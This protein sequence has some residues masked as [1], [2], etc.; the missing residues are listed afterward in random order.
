MKLRP[1]TSKSARI[2]RLFLLVFFLLALDSPGVV[3]STPRAS[4]N[5]DM[6]SLGV[7]QSKDPICVGDVVNVT[8]QWGPNINYD[9]GGG[10]APVLPLAGPTRIKLQAG[11]GSFYPDASFTPGSYSG[12]HT[13]TYTAEKAGKEKIFAVAWFGDSSDAIASDTFTIKACDY[14]FTLDG[15]FNLDVQTEGISYSVEYTVK[16][17]GVLTAPD[18]DKPFNLEGNMKKVKLDAVYTSF[19]SSKCTLFT[20]EPGTGG[21]FVDAKTEPRQNGNG[22]VLQLAPPQDMAWDVDLSFA[23]DGNPLSISGVYPSTSSDPWVSAEFPMGSGQQSVKLDMFEIPM[24]KMNGNPGVSA[25]YTAT[26][27]LEKVQPK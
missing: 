21:G 9:P 10:L 26:L 13:V 8:V 24:N 17:H 19:S 15:V 23:C 12:T 11:L 25:S 3:A 20:Y 18:P 14:K 7:S 6:F 1:S 16:S 4:S 5:S 27:T 22:M 2:T